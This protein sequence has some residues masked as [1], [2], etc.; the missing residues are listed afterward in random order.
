MEAHLQARPKKNPF[1]LHEQDRLRTLAVEKI[2]N[3]FLPN[4]GI[5]K[6]ILIGSSVKGTFG[7]YEVPGFRGSL[8]SDF[9]FIIFVSDTYS[10]PPWLER[11]LSGKPFNNKTLDLAYRKKAFIED[12]YDAEIFFIRES[13]LKDQP[14]RSLAEEAGIPFDKQSLNPFITVWEKQVD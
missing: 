12:I 3:V 1:S 7:C 9:D 6:I 13:S 11:E 14:I 8:F 4:E 2:Q 5:D 10:I